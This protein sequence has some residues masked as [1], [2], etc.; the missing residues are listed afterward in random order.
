L[1]CD[2]RKAQ[3]HRQANRNLRAKFDQARPWRKTLRT[4]AKTIDTKSKVLYHIAAIRTYLKC[5]AKLIGVAHQF[6]FSRHRSPLRITHLDAQ[7]APGM[8]TVRGPSSKKDKRKRCQYVASS[9]GEH[10]GVVSLRQK[11]IDR[12]GRCFLSARL[13]FAGI[14]L[15]RIHAVVAL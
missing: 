13:P 11:L 2:W 3:T 10:H 15:N 6:G 4:Y 7:F 12:I 1:G 9:V 5:P 8:L 14:P